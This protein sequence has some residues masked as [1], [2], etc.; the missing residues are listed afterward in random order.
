MDTRSSTPPTRRELWNVQPARGWVVYTL[1]AFIAAALLLGTI[2]YFDLL[3][4]TRAVCGP[5]RSAQAI[6]ANTDVGRQLAATFVEAADELGCP[7]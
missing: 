3:G 6:D 5:L 7:R 2:A 4:R 1:M